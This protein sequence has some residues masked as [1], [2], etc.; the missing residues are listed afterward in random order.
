M[1]AC[2]VPGWYMES[3]K[4]IKYMF[5]KAHAVAYLIMAV[6]L[7]WFKIYHPVAY[8]AT[9]LTVRGNDI[10]YEAA[11]GGKEVAKRH[12]RELQELLKTD[13]SAKN[14]DTLT[15]LLNT[16]EYLCRGFAFLPIELGKSRANE[17]MV[18]DGK[19]RLPFLALKG[20]GAIQAAALENATL[21]GQKYLSIEE[22]QNASGV[23]GAVIEALDKAGALGGLPKSNQI[24]FF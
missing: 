1:K 10:D 6:K 14:E 9:Y 21:A 2:G 19:I 16:N 24:S 11:I 12:I 20:V 7:M 5:P 17:Y 22:L 15:T 4:K 18:E 23:P 8:Y 13:K 3:C